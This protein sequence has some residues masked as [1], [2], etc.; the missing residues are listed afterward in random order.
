MSRLE[1]LLYHTTTDHNTG[2]EVND[3]DYDLAAEL[4]D[5]WRNQYGKDIEESLNISSYN[6]RQIASQAT[7]ALRAIV[8]RELDLGVEETPDA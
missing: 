4:R 3:F 6:V 1:Y 8:E 7:D 5:Q 2:L